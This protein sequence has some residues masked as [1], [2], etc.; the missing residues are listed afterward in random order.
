VLASG[1]DDGTWGMDRLIL[2]S[3]NWPDMG[4]P[5][6]TPVARTFESGLLFDPT[7][8]KMF[9]TS[10]FQNLVTVA[11]DSNTLCPTLLSVNASTINPY[12]TVVSHEN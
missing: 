11:Q 1:S 8:W 2:L 9:A 12:Y 3:G 5:R 4:L 6:A 10:S 7:S